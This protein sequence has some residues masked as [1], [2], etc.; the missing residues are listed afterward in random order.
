MASSATT[1]S[2][3]SS[4]IGCPPSEKLAKGNFHLWK[5]QVLSAIRGAEMEHYLEPET[6]VPP[7]KIA[8]SAEKPDELIPNPVYK[9]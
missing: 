9:T 2:V 5:L 6:V 1:L 7:K 3:I 8:K 4:L